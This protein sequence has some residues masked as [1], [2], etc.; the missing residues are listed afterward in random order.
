MEDVE[1][2]LDIVRDAKLYVKTTQIVLV[3]VN[4]T[5]LCSFAINK[6]MTMIN[7]DG[8]SKT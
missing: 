8:M 1:V 4:K 7:N 3:L 5:L 6:W 2:N